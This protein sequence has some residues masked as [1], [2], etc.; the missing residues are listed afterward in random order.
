MEELKINEKKRKRLESQRRY[1]EKNRELLNEKNRRYR[2]ENKETVELSRKRWIDQ[3][4]EKAIESHRNRQRRYKERN[5]EKVRVSQKLWYDANKERYRENKLK[6]L[7]NLNL[8]DYEKM[9]QEQKS[10]CAICSAKVEEER[11]KVLVVDHNHLTGNVR[12]LLCHK[13]NT[14]LGLFRDNEAYLLKAVE[15]LRKFSEPLDGGT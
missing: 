10:C 14:G 8:N 9:L 13:C 7:Y 11:D 12:G 1:R 4:P 15:Y 5:L 2:E 6:R 3:N